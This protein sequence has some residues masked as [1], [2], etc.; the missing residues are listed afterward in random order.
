[1]R[2]AYGANVSFESIPGYE[3]YWGR[4]K[5]E[6]AKILILGTDPSVPSSKKKA[7]R[8]EILCPFGLTEFKD[9]LDYERDLRRTPYFGEICRN[10][11]CLFQ[12]FAI[13]EGDY[14]SFIKN[15]IIV[16]NAVDKRLKINEKYVTTGEC[17]RSRVSNKKA[18]RIV[19]YRNSVIVSTSP[20]CIRNRVSRTI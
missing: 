15:N 19:E 16:M 17:F 10:L 11:E 2:R 18:W 1:M 7:N 5:F 14:L 6:Q 20:I 4:E 3:N 12:V 13:D 9:C 8:S